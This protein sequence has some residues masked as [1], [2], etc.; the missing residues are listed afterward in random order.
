MSHSSAVDC[1]PC[2]TSGETERGKVLSSPCQDFVLCWCQIHD[3]LESD[4]LTTR[5]G[6]EIMDMAASV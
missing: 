5:Q 3:Y 4:V 2:E 1:S 6:L